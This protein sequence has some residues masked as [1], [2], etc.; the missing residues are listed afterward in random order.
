MV[1][2]LLQLSTMT[3]TVINNPLVRDELYLLLMRNIDSYKKTLWMEK[4]DVILKQKQR[5]LLYHPQT[6][7]SFAVSILFIP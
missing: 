6:R 7:D 3:Q 2:E 4:Q 1:I 5:H